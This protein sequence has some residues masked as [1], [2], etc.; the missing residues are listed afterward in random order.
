MNLGKLPDY[1]VDYAGVLS[2]GATQE[3]RSLAATYQ[4]QTTNELAAVLI[5]NRNGNELFDISMKLFR[6]NGLGD[7]QRNN[8]VLLVISTEE[9]KIRITVGYGLE[10]AL[11]DVSASEI[12][13]K[14]IRPLV[15]SGDFAGA[16]KAYYEMTPKYIGGEYTADAATSDLAPKSVPLWDAL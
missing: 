5:P 12:I 7:K 13:E 8:G 3:L 16:V 11:P 15:N 10:G 2:E 4:Q 14:Y 6:E 9:K 1:V